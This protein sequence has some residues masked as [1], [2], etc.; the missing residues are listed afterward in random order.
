MGTSVNL[1]LFLLFNIDTGRKKRAAATQ[2][3]HLPNRW[4]VHCCT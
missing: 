2:E 1:S 4:F 3:M